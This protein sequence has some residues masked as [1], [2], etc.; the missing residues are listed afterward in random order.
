MR[1]PFNDDELRRLR[2]RLPARHD[3]PERPLRRALPGALRRRPLLRRRSPL[4]PEWMLS[5][6]ADLLW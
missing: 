1:Q 3:L 4:L 5:E 6:R 2:A